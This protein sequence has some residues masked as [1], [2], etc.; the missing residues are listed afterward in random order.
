[1]TAQLTFSLFSNDTV[2]FFFSISYK[3]KLNHISEGAIVIFIVQSLSHVQFFVTQWTAVCQPSVSITVFLSLLKLMSI[4]SVMPSNRF[5]LC[6]LLLLL[7]SI[8][9][10]IRVLSNE[11]ALR[12]RWP[13]YWNFT[14]SI[15]PSN[16]YSG[17]ISIRIDWFDLAVQGSQE[18]SPTPQFK[19]IKSSVLSL[20]YSPTLTSILDHWKNHSLD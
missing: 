16:K 19:S 15:S 3:L 7:S 18:S 13:K 17:L 5:I 1:M 11:S 4:E 12:I 20:L 6:Q 9:P 2:F 14:F 10:R 8:F